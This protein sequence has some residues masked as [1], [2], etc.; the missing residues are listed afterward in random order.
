MDRR[1]IL[2]YAGFTAVGLVAGSRVGF[3]E[4]V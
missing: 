2:K 1:S 4:D 3:A